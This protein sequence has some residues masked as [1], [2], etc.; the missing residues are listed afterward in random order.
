MYKYLFWFSSKAPKE[1]ICLW[2]KLWESKYSR[3]RTLFSNSIFYRNGKR[4]NVHTADNFFERTIW[5]KNCIEFLNWILRIWWSSKFWFGTLSIAIKAV[6][7]AILTNS[8]TRTYGRRMK[9]WPP[10][11]PIRCL[12]HY[13]PTN[14]SILKAY[15]LGLIYWH[16][17]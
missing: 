7:L 8:A 15:I 6:L 9:M 17:W 3:K 14:Y 2:E 4:A 1:R 11:T 10:F 13:L 12:V 5:L 16:S